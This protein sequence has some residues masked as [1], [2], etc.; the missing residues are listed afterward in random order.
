MA[1]DQLK[2]VF[3]YRFDHDNEEEHVSKAC[4]W[5]AALAA[6]AGAHL[7]AIIATQHHTVSNVMG[8]SLVS[9]VV[10]DQNRKLTEVASARTEALR[11]L[12]QASGIDCDVRTLSAPYPDVRATLSSRSRLYDVLVADAASD[13][14]SMR[15]ELLV[16]VLFHA[17]R[18]VIVVPPSAST[19]NL[20]QI[21][22][23][24]DG[25][26]PAARALADALPLLR[27][28][29]N[30][31]VVNVMGDKELP[32]GGRAADVLPH[33]L[34]HGVAAQAREL[35][36]NGGDAAHTLLHHAVS[37][38]AGLLVM[39]AYAHSRFRQMVFGGVTS[40]LLKDCPV[41]LLMSH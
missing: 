15:R 34:R 31:D 12:T 23:G 32:E 4:E 27:G 6:Q 19:P 14:S 11:A 9:N 10:G 39:G 24:W 41:P 5:A 33:L 38:K 1:L 30:V 40:A 29:K 37:T 8:A 21:V 25:T 28:A 7:G 17:A 18:P 13:A 2:S 3:T 20:D 16:D 35:P 22:V 36:L 26:A